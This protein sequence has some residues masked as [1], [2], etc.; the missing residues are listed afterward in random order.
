MCEDSCRLSSYRNV[1]QLIWYL[2][3]KYT[4]LSKLRQK[5]N[6]IKKRTI[7]YNICIY[8]LKTTTLHSE[9]SIF[10]KCMYVKH[11][12]N[13]Q[14]LKEKYYNFTMYMNVVNSNRRKQK[15][16][17]TNKQ[18]SNKQKQNSCK[19]HHCIEICMKRIL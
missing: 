14:T 3:S 7:M 12:Y 1:E 15:Q 19:Y 4:K 18:K 17:K 5:Q 6:K 8:I 11:K 2:Y 13:I 10:T 16:N 9:L